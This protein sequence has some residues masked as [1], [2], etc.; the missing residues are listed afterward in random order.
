MPSLPRDPDEQLRLGLRVIEAAYEEKARQTDHE[1]QQ[2]RTY[3]K[4][5]QQ[6]VSQLERRVAELEQMVS[7][8]DERARQLSEEKAHLQQE[9][10]MTQRDLSK[11]DTCLTGR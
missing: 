8:R 11:L 5:R 1:L 4:E 3:S 6:Q 10:K 9:L 7:D 2:L